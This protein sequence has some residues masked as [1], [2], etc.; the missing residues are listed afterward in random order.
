M[1]GMHEKNHEAMFGK[2]AILEIFKDTA[3]KFGV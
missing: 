2:F 3:Q 1:R